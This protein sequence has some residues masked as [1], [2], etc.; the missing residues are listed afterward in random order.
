[1]QNKKTTTRNKL[2]APRCVYVSLML[3][4]EWQSKKS[5]KVLKSKECNKDETKNTPIHRTVDESNG[6]GYWHW[7]FISIRRKYISNVDFATKVKINKQTNKQRPF[8]QMIQTFFFLSK[9]V[10]TFSRINML[11][12]QMFFSK[13]ACYLIRKPKINILSPLFRASFVS[14]MTFRQKRRAVL[15]FLNER[16]LFEVENSRFTFNLPDF[17]WFFCLTKGWSL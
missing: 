8:P 11:N 10:S 7:L 12:K 2:L 9:P 1:M 3:S 14:R 5:N 16:S 17:S 13:K 4:H 6:L 15:W